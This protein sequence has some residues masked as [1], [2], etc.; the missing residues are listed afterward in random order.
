MKSRFA[1][2][3]YIC[4]PC[5]EKKSFFLEGKNVIKLHMN[6]PVTVILK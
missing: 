3:I 6:V 2:E 4:K 5:F 1:R